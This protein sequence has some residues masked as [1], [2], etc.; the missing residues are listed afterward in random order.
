MRNDHFS[1]AASHDGAN[2]NYFTYFWIAGTIIIHINLCFD[3]ILY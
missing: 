2:L 3:Y 1:V